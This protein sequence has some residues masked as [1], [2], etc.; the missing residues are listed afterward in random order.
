MLTDKVNM[1]ICQEHHYPKIQVFLKSFLIIESNSFKVF[2]KIFFPIFLIVKPW[3]LFFLKISE[4]A[5]SFGLL[6]FFAILNLFSNLYTSL[7][8]STLGPCNIFASY[9]AASKGFCPLFLLLSRPRKL[10]NRVYEKFEFLQKYQL[11]K[12]QQNLSF[13][14]SNYDKLLLNLNLNF[15]FFHNRIYAMNM[16][17]NN[18]CYQVFEFFL[19]SK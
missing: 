15:Q 9:L 2:F 14:Y 7:K 19:S 8:L 12:Y 1:Q 3:F 16:S 17:W 5:S 6:I 18:Y 10:S 11:Y 13:V 4:Y